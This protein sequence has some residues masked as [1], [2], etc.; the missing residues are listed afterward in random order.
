MNG[1]CVRSGHSTTDTLTSLNVFCNPSLST[2]I[3]VVIV[4]QHMHSQT[5]YHC[6]HMPT[7]GDSY[8]M[9]FMHTCKFTACFCLLFHLL[10][11][12][13]KYTK[14]QQSVPTK[15]KREMGS[16]TLCNVLDRVVKEKLKMFST[17]KA[18]MA[19]FVCQ[20]AQKH[21]LNG[22]EV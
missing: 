19:I 18:R 17:Q 15:L 21:K 4:L 12:I 10:N 1:S 3:Y 22:K 9:K 6:V 5:I 20:S 2:K 13:E 8:V 14:A 16:S 11:V 7:S